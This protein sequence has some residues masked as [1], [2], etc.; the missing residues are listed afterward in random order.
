M[1]Q[2]QTGSL[3]QSLLRRIE[4]GQPQW[5]RSADVGAIERELRALHR[6]TTLNRAGGE[7]PIPIAS[8][9]VALVAQGK[10]VVENG[11]LRLNQPF[12][13]PRRSAPNISFPVLKPVVVEPK[14]QKRGPGRPRKYPRPEDN[15]EDLPQS[16]VTPD[17]PKEKAMEPSA[18]EMPLVPSISAPDLIDG[19]LD[20]KHVISWD[21]S[22]GTSRLR[23]RCVNAVDDEMFPTNI[24][25][26]SF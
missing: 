16:F 5:M 20:P 19:Y 1:P 9:L 11:R 21:V 8:D 2:S 18:V 17:L 3:S 22:Q 12:I 26:L 7:P 24:T 4:R 25:V 13:P 23:L 10:G 14:A 6:N 15:A